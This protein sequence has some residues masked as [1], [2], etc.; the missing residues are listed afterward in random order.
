MVRP[1]FI[2]PSAHEPQ[3]NRGFASNGRAKDRFVGRPKQYLHPDRFD[4]R[5]VDRHVANHIDTFRLFD[6]EFTRLSEGS[7]TFGTL[8]RR[9]SEVVPG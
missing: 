5:Y 7:G 2:A 9:S 8:N 6:R 1:V 3:S 4:G